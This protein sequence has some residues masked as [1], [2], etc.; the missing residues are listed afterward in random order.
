[1]PDHVDGLIASCVSL[2]QEETA[3]WF[4]DCAISVLNQTPIEQQ[5]TAAIHYLL[6]STKHYSGDGSYGL[7]YFP[8]TCP[9][10]FDF[11][12]RRVEEFFAP[13]F[14]IYPQAKIDKYTA[15]FF[16]EYAE[17]R[18]GRS[19]GVIECDGH[20]YHER[21][22]EQAAHDKARDRYFQAEGLLVFRFTG[23]EIHKDAVG[24]ASEALR[25]FSRA[26]SKRPTKNG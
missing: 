14:I 26:A 23:S 12:S 2:L 19:L 8:N 22:K 9:E 21:T 24:C 4:W 13:G 18:V 16:V 15:N 10:N 5:M 25:N 11:R 17:Y 20:D 3:E 6:R 7:H 1:M